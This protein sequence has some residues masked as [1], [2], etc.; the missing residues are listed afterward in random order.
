M[1]AIHTEKAFEELITAHLVGHGWVA[2][3]DA[4]FDPAVALDRGNLFAFIEAT[5][6][7]SSG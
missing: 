4:D 5:Q 3:R 2:G 1:T 6:R 7:S